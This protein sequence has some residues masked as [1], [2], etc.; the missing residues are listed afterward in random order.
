MAD[1]IFDLDALAR[2]ANEV[3]FQFRFDGEVYTCPSDISL[4]MIKLL[5]AEDVLGAM[6]ELLGDE[7]WDRIVAADR[8]FGVTTMAK[9]LDAYRKHLGIELPNS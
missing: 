4:E 7:Q 6:R 5:E 1:D 8:V 9:V 2:E 3:P